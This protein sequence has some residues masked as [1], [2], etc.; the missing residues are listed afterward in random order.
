[1]DKIFIT[2]ASQV[3]EVDLRTARLGT[4]FGRLDLASQL[5][6]LAVELLNMDFDA[7]PRERIGIC[8]G[9]RM[10]SLAADLDFWR[11]RDAVGGPSPTLFTY[12]LPSAAIGEIAIR[13]RLTGP[14][15]CLVG[16]EAV[17]AEAGD[18]LRRGE[19]DGCLCVGCNVVTPALAEMVKSPPVARACALFLRRGGGGWR[20]F[21]ENDRDIESVCAAFCA[22]DSEHRI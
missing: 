8:L 11:G 7:Q 13:H 15:L 20:Q 4:R 14:D 22:Q 17:L 9:A 19:V 3:T 2:A 18:W 10:G 21:G 5:A 12:T 6:L 1:M 16:V